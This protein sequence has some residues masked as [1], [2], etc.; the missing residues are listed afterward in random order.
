MENISTWMHV[1]TFTVEQAAAL[2]CGVDPNSLS[3]VDQ[4]N[5][6]EVLAAK[7][8]IVNGIYGGQLRAYTGKNPY[9]SIGKHEKTLINREDLVELARSKGVYPAFLFDT[10]APFQSIATAAEGGKTAG[11][12]GKNKG[13]RP[14]EYDWDTFIFEIIRQANTPDGL[15]EKQAT[16]IRCMLEWCNENFG[17]EPAESSVKQR[18]SKIYNY[19][20]KA[21]NHKD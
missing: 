14:Q 11:A 3:P 10:L 2:W 1:E 8:L 15:P 6:S 4:F 20:E 18:I 5:P 7:Q 19:L 9:H 12:R 21:K 17:S 13:G 16:L